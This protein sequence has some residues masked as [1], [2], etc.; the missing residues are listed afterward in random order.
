MTGENDKKFWW[1]EIVRQ[2]KK[3][4]TETE[5][6]ATNKKFGSHDG[7]DEE[8]RDHIVTEVNN[9]KILW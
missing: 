8:T 9:D 2:V 7:I 4:H 3:T 6:K 5:A 1:E